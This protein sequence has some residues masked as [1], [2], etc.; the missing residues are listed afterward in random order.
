[1]NTKGGNLVYSKTTT[2]KGLNKSNLLSGLLLYFKNNE[3]NAKDACEVI[4]ENRPL[5]KKYV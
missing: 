4:M 3:D 2:K 5:V 1:M